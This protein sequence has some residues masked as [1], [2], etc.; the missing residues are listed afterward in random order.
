MKSVSL[1]RDIGST[2][3]PI[4]IVEGNHFDKYRSRNPF[5]VLMMKRFLSDCREL[6][7]TVAPARILEVGCGPGDLAAQVLCTS[8]AYY[9]G[10][11]ISQR[12]IDKAKFALPDRDFVVAS[13]AQ[14]PFEDSFADLVVCCEVIEHLGYPIEAIA[15]IER[16]S[17]GFAL[18]SVPWEPIWRIL[19][20]IRGKYWSSLGNTPGHL[21]HFSR[22]KIRN[23]VSTKFEIVA[24]RHP[25]PW[26]MLLL[27]KT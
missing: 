10:T 25:F 22:K 19:N 27:R 23:L 20:G 9:I 7:E 2:S 8:E 14:L 17:S 18:V 24:E 26:T 3:E 21:Q 12:E 6:V 16:V 11:D 13:A 4:S 1:A 5:H 15:E